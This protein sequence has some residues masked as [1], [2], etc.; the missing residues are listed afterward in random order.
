MAS[1]TIGQLEKVR[2]LAASGTMLAIGGVRAGAKSQLTL[3]DLATKKVARTIDVPSH[4]LALAFHGN[5]LVAGC[6]DGFIRTYDAS[7]GA[8]GKDAQAHAG[9][10]F[11]LAVSQDGA[12]LASAGADGNARLW[13][14]DTLTGGAS[15]SLST[16]ALRAVAVSAT[17]LAA[18]GDDGVVRV[19][20]KGSGARR[21]MPGHAGPVLSLCFTPRD[22]R[23]ASSGDDGTVRFWFLDGAIEAEVRGANE[24]G[25]A[26]GAY[27]MVFGPVPADV[28]DAPDRLFSAGADAKVKVWRL[29]ERRKPKSYDLLD[30]IRAVT[31]VP[32]VK[33]QKDLGTIVAGGD[34]RSL[35]FITVGADGNPLDATNT[36][37]HGF[38]LFE[39]QIAGHQRPGREAA[40]RALAALE[41]KE[42]LELLLKVLSGDREPEVRALAAQLLGQHG[43]RDARPALRERLDDGHEKVRAAAL[44]AL[45]QLETE[46]PIAALRAGL[47][48]K[49]AEVRVAA[50]KQLPPLYPASPLVPGL[51]SGRLTDGDATVR[52]AALDALAKLH[53]AGSFEP[54]RIAFERGT[55][56][57]RAE[58][59]V[60][61][62]MLGEAQFPGTWWM[63]GRALDDDDA[64]VRRIGFAVRVLTRR[65]LAALLHG[66]F[67]NFERMVTDI[68]RRVAVLRRTA[69]GK[70]VSDAELAE[71]RQ[72][73]GLTAS[74][75]EGELKDN[76]FEPLLLAMSCRTADT[77]LR[78]T[79]AMLSLLE[80][81]RAIGALLQL[82]RDGAAQIRATVASVL[83]HLETSQAEQRLV[84]MLEDAEASVR[85][86]AADA[87]NARARQRPLELAKGLLRS[88]FED[89]RKRGL[90]V[91]MQLPEDDRGAAAETLLES[92]IEDEAAAVRAEAFRTL[93]AWHSSTPEE[94]IDRA[95]AARFPDVRLKAIDE[96]CAIGKVPRDDE[97]KPPVKVESWVT[98]RL[99]A[100]VKDRDASVG[101]RAFEAVRRLET[102]Q[103][104]KACLLALESQLADVRKAGA[105]WAAKISKSNADAIRS[106]LVKAIQDETLGVQLAALE[107]LDVLFTEDE[108]PLT[109]GLG[110]DNFEVRIRAAEL[111]AKRGD[112]R[113]IEPMRGFLVDK[114]LVKRHGPAYIEPLRARAA[115]ALATLGSP[116]VIAFASQTLLK[117][118]NPHVR[119]QAARALCNA[120]SAEAVGPQ[121]DA[122][123]HA[124]VA[125]RSWAA[126]GLARQ[127]DTRGL[128]VLTGTLRDSHVPIREGA[129]RALAALGSQ[130]NNGLLAGL[131][132]P[133]RWI[134]ETFFAILL[135]R[136]WKAW[137]TGKPAELPTA[138]LSSSRAEIRFAAARA[139]E[140]RT[141]V[142]PYVDYVIEVLLPPKPEKAADMKDWPAEPEREH[143]A[144]A[145]ADMLAADAAPDRYAAGQ[146]LLLRRRPLEYFAEVKRVTALKPQGA[147]LVPDTTPRAPARGAAPKGDWLRRLFASNVKA[148]EVSEEAQAQLRWL[149]FGAYM[150]ILREAVKE[151]QGGRVRRDAVD[152]LVALAQAGQPPASSA[153]PALVRALDD[154]DHL[155][156]RQAWAGLKK[157]FT[158]DPSDNAVKYAL[159]SRSADIANAALDELAARPNA[160][161]KPLIGSMLDSSLADVR[162]HAFELLVR[163][164]PGDSL[165]ALLQAFSCQHADLRLSVVERLAASSDPRVNDALIRALESEHDDLRLRA[166]EL[167]ADRRDDRCVAVLA[168]FIRSDDAA[169]SNRARTALVKLG[170]PAAVKA[171]A[172]R[173]DE[174]TTAALRR[175]L[176]TA[177]GDVRGGRDGVDALVKLVADDE[178][179]AEAFNAGMKL[180]NFWRP[181]AEDAEANEKRAKEYPRDGA[182]L[183]RFLEA[184]IKSKKPE[185][186][187]QAA[188]RMDVG[189]EKELDALLV[190]AFGDR[191]AL[192]RTEAARRYANRVEKLGADPAPLEELLRQGARELMLSAATGLASKR[193]ASA[194]RPLLL[195][196]RAGEAGEREQAL[197]ALGTLG[198]VRCLEELELVASGGTVEVPFEPSMQAAALEALGRLHS[199]LTDAQEKKRVWER[200]EAAASEGALQEAG[201]DALLAVGEAR[202]GASLERIALITVTP[203]NVRLR[204]IAN[205]GKLGQ[206]TSESA[207]AKLLRDSDSMVRAA[208]RKALGKLFAAE[209]MRVALLAADSNYPDIAAP[210]IAFLVAEAEPSGLLAR[211]EQPLQAPLR[212]ALRTGL[213][214][215]A[216]LPTDALVKGVDA[217]LPAAREDLAWLMGVHALSATPLN[218]GDRSTRAK[219]LASAATKT[220][221]RWSKAL[222][223]EK[224]AEERAWRRLLW[225]ATLHAAKELAPAAIKALQA[226]ESPVFVRREAARALTKLGGADAV[227]A[228]ESAAKDRDASVRRSAIA[229][230][231]KLDTNRARSLITTMTPLDAVSLAPVAATDAALL[232]A[233]AGRKVALPAFVAK[234]EKQVLMELVKAAKDEQATLAALSALG[235]I[236][237]DDVVSFLEGLAFTGEGG[238]GDDDDGGDDDGDDDDGGDDDGGDDDDGDEEGGGSSADVTMPGAKRFEFEEDGSSKFWEVVVEGTMMKVRY[239]K[240]GSAGQ[241]KLKDLGSAGGATREMEKMIR[242]KAGKGYQPV[243]PKGRKAL[244]VVKPRA[245]DEGDDPA[246]GEKETWGTEEL[247]KAAFRAF[248][249]AQRLTEK[250]SSAPKWFSAAEVKALADQA[251][252][253]APLVVPTPSA[254]AAPAPS[255][256]TGGGDV[257]DRLVEEL[258][259]SVRT[260]GALEDYGVETVGELAD[261]LDN[262]ELSDLGKKSIEE[263]KAVL[264]S[265]GITVAPPDEGDEGGDDEDED[266]EED[267][268]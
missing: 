128:S 243:E 190:S 241:V 50:V 21:D 220:A 237:G 170:S 2:A 171:L 213:T 179:G 265:L 163:L 129:I 206:E 161:G 110:A 184:G 115:G 208:A 139:L 76:E 127:G 169:P 164:S 80:D 116:R 247:R 40:A 118:E 224:V 39:Q 252:A 245:D 125:V 191:E 60:R 65:P 204:A 172:A 15:H 195:F 262:G 176:I 99:E 188:E 146:A 113:V 68:A 255:P 31:F 157:L 97:A 44:A 256:A 207:L 25:H 100:A 228:L 151:E 196:V 244:A 57:L 218:E 19:V 104:P 261:M 122:L 131:D 235:R 189:P 108:G 175:P 183:V 168:A 174:V 95:L 87:W 226:S 137:R 64:E 112:E 48:S 17:H 150:G 32:P 266:Y 29:D 251:Q 75:T 78:G 211:L 102:Q 215:R 167:L 56:D 264:A 121:L 153:I 152:R 96:L 229:G 20:T 66:R 141:D 155:V 14:L 159:T 11:A 260:S 236:G 9:G 79:V 3:F 221:E 86:A 111:L 231:A 38:R 135:A 216:A 232:V 130:G 101:L 4:V 212:D 51:V 156:R 181:D 35:L 81:Q 52:L 26:G 58:A 223:T 202:A 144:V 67:G 193:A 1:F 41:E 42:A 138:A 217:Q 234:A 253:G 162:K 158:Q 47:G 222:G 82:S 126:E 6:L 49:F 89:M 53:P 119:E 132:D 34:G 54:F 267:D 36:G 210:A 105:T 248:K 94:A 225:A 37:D 258:E 249:R 55:P 209:P 88:A 7:T 93:W 147:T 143:L 148:A 203:R 257:R 43:R 134:Q 5:R 92:A 28:A 8:A 103:S 27:A 185:L 177:L 165:E 230:L 173:L 23:L 133:E 85:T 30:V 187:Q 33:G 72:A 268:E 124:D 84:A 200:I 13:S 61:A 71:A 83:Q 233:D 63:T 160:A 16:Q 197:K 106:Q 98:E 22:G 120:N 250:R 180:G 194:Y 140:L 154:D 192:V 18:G 149:A 186:R 123:A 166:A 59:M 219:A 70:E 24:Q 142:E 201:V 214:H 91:L 240:I 145:L 107:S 69:P 238:G 239:G 10:V 259:L 45:Q 46:N 73:I 182:T 77:A 109:A 114:E 198:D 74:S 178:V 227:A 263:L 199:R 12:E 205:L 254:S 62:L 136:D 117:D 246:S 90:A 242:E